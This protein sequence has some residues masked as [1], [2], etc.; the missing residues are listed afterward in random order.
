MTEQEKVTSLL[1]MWL[2]VQQNPYHYIGVNQANVA[3][4]LNR[5]D[6][7]NK[8]ILRATN[9]IID[10]PTG[11]LPNPITIPAEYQ[12]LPTKSEWVHEKRYNDWMWATDFV[13]NLGPTDLGGIQFV[14]WQNAEA[15]GNYIFYVSCRHDR[16]G[17]R[18]KF[19]ADKVIVG[20]DPSA[21]IAALAQDPNVKLGAIYVGFYQD[22][23]IIWARK[24]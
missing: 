9:A 11:K 24:L 20:T 3:T 19:E 22:R 12:A 16:S 8:T 7:I 5:L 14:L 15:G 1:G 10:D 6:E 23:G 18:Y 4:T 21:R 2:D 17:Q 13:N